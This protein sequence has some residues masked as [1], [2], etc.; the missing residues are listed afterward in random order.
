MEKANLPVFCT[1]TDHGSIS[2]PI[3]SAISSSVTPLARKVSSSSQFVQIADLVAWC[4]FAAVDRHPNNE[5]ASGWYDEYLSLRD[6]RGA[7]RELVP[8]FKR[9]RKK[10]GD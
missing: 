10:T 7:P 3:N 1:P 6:P 5:F 4:A 9:L 8:T 2:S